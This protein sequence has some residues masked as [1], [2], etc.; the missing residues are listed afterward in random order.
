MSGFNVSPAAYE[1]FNIAGFPVTNSFV[2]SV[3]VSLVIA[4]GINL[5]IGKPSLRP[6]RAQGVMESAIEGLQGIFRPVVG[7][8]M[9]KH[10]F[11]LLVAF[12]LFILIQNWF[13]LIPGVGTVGIVDTHEG[14]KHLT[15]FLRPANT[16]LTNAVAL[17]LLSFGAWIF[18]V[19]KYAGIG[20]FLKELFGSKVKKSEVSA[21]L[22]YP[23]CLLFFLVGCVEV[24]SILI[25]PVSLSFRLFG[26][27]FGGENLLMNISGMFSWLIPV[28]FYLMELMVGLVQ[29]FVFT[30]L[31]AVYI[32][33]ACNHAHEEAE[34]KHS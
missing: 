24:I 7:E 2:M 25:R 9:L 21:L 13:G 12:F 4:A 22:F 19:L 16:D 27:M 8:R 15:Y 10:T 14:E 34:H 23:M 30:M 33:L 5:A 29:A 18:Y 1:L 28:P 26:N 20:N 3:T 32:G 11:P 31:T 17:G 6:N